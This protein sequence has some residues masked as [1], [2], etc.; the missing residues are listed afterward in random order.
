MQMYKLLC[1]PS[2]LQK[3]EWLVA[4]KAASANVTCAGEDLRV[5][6]AFLLERCYVAPEFAIDPSD[7]YRISFVTV[8]WK[9]DSKFSLVQQVECPHRKDWLGCELVR[10]CTSAIS[11]QRSC[12]NKR[13]A[14]NLAVVL[15][16]P[17]GSS[18]QQTM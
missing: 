8:S 13:S 7:V 1:I 10:L 11:L 9:P 4:C 16:R 2:N 6:L 12:R 14:T 3:K 5:L 15:F 17:H 18:S